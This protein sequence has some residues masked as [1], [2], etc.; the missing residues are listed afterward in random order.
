[1]CDGSV[2]K[3]WFNVFR[4]IFFGMLLIIVILIGELFRVLV[5]KFWIVGMLILVSLVLDGLL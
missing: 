2:L 3:V 4:I 1:M 5:R